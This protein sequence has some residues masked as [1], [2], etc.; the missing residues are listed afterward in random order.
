M[1][2]FHLV[3]DISGNGSVDD[4]CWVSEKGQLTPPIQ[5]SLKGVTNST[6]DYSWDK[7]END[8]TN[9][10]GRDSEG[11]QLYKYQEPIAKRIGEALFRTFFPDPIKQRFDAYRNKLAWSRLALH[12]PRSLF[13]LPWEILK[14][15]SDKAGKFLSLIGSVVRCDDTAGGSA[16]GSSLAHKNR[17]KFLTVSSDPADRPILGAISWKSSK[18]IKFQ[19][20]NPATFTKFKSYVA[21]V[22]DCD[23]FVFW[24]HGDIDPESRFGVLVFERRSFE[25]ENMLR[26]ISHPVQAPNLGLVFDR[27]PMSVAYVLA[28]ESAS[29]GE[30]KIDFAS[31]IVG[32]LLDRTS[33]AFLVG[34][35]T[36]LDVH[37]AEACLDASM[38]KLRADPRLPI[39]LAITAGRNAIFDIPAKGPYKRSALD[40]WVPVSYTRPDFLEVLSKPALRADPA[41]VK[42]PESEQRPTATPAGGLL[43]AE[44]I[45]GL[46]ALKNVVADSVRL[47]FS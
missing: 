20:I 22:Q 23:G 3:V 43:A 2:F 41:N 34:A 42:V 30:N 32:S 6:P 31:S 14:D 38:G 26:F 21:S 45:T 16:D 24:G 18:Q 33:L 15:P 29:W 4:D 36:N 10:R 28:C 12:L 40:W 39:D 11:P 47:L 37:A 5:V 9:L 46:G 27:S 17:L 25:L 19:G 13:V 44:N 35:Q 7:F 1:S 8:L